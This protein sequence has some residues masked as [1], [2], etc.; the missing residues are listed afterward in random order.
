MDEPISLKDYSVNF[1][2]YFIGPDN[3][4]K[5]VDPRIGH[6]RLWQIA[7]VFENGIFLKS[8]KTSI[9]YHEVDM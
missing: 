8:E 7:V 3:K 4:I 5:A 9:D 1:Y 2:F 6:F